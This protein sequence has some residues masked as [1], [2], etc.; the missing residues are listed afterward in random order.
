MQKKVFLRN[1]VASGTV[2]GDVAV[3]LA[4]M[5]EKNQLS[6]D[7]GS[8]EAGTLC[9]GS[10]VIV[11]IVKAEIYKGYTTTPVDY[12]G[13]MIG[14]IPEAAT[15]KNLADVLPICTYLDVDDAKEFKISTP[16]D[17]VYFAY[18]VNSGEPFTGYTIYL[19]NDLDMTGVKMDPI[20][21]SGNHIFSN[22]D[23]VKNFQGTFDHNQLVQISWHMQRQ[24]LMTLQ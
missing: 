6:L 4:I 21:S 20:G 2:T 5:G 1:C 3:A 14:Y 18:L 15:E 19:E 23:Q 9:D 7:L 12:S 17:L 22:K 8:A 13:K 10:A 24:Y 16:D 11:N